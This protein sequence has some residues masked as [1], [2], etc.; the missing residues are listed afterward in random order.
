MPSG[1]YLS[2]VYKQYEESIADNLDKEVKKRGA[3]RL[4]WDA[5]YKEAKH[6]GRYHLGQLWTSA[7]LPVPEGCQ[8]AACVKTR[9]EKMAS[10]S[11]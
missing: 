10:D 11:F 6:L 8:A 5:S 7:K 9:I 1:R 2:T 4:H 3:R